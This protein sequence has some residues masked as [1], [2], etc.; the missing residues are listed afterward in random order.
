MK[1]KLKACKECGKMFTPRCGTQV[2]CS[3]P[4][5][6]YCETCGKSIEY[7]C[8]PKE[9]PRYCSTT[10]RTEGVKKH[11]LE[12]YG[13]EN[14][15]QLDTVRDRISKAK[16]G[17]VLPKSRQVNY[18]QC[19]Y[20]G[21]MFVSNGTQVYCEG[22]HHAICK[23]CGKEFEVNPRQPSSTCSRKCSAQLRK[24]TL[25]KNKHTCEIC[26]KIFYSSSNTAKYCEGPHYRS[27]PICGKLIEFHSLRDPIT[28]CSSTCA[29]KLR[30]KTCFDTFGT[31]VASQC[32]DV[33]HKLSQASIAAEE[34][35]IQTCL[36]RYGVPYACQDRNIRDK[37]R[38]TVSSASCQDRITKTCLSRYGVRHSSQNPDTQRKN[39]L[40]RSQIV[41]C[42][43]TSVDSSYEKIFYDFLVRNDIEFMYQ[44]RSI[45][46]EYNGKTHKTFIDFDV[47]G[48]LFECKG[49]HLLSGCFDHQGVP[50]AAKIDVYKK[51]HVILLTDDYAVNMFGKPNSS[52][53]N[54]LKYSDKCPYPLIGVDISLFTDTPEFPYRKDR[55]KCF[56]DVSVDGKK[57]SHEA[58]YDEVIR[59][60]MILNRIQYS[61]GFIDNKQILTALNVTRIC[62]QPSWFSKRRAKDLIMKYC[63]SNTIVDSFAGW[64]ARC[65]AT[66]ELHRI[67]VGIDL[68]KD[69]VEWHHEN[70]RNNISL[71]NALDFIYTKTCSVF[72]CPPY[73]DPKTGKCFEDYNFEGFDDSC[74]Q[75]SQCDWLKVVMKNVP[76][77][78]E[79]V[80]VCK[81]VDEGFEK[82][83]VDIIHNKSHFGDNREYI[84]CVPGICSSNGTISN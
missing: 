29:T 21:K 61:G 34:A 3:G 66:N 49:S 20:C 35:K 47:N 64:G 70:G 32:E 60:N 68:N 39:A 10:C 14:V 71:G 76:N 16:H 7:T 22:P 41:A 23:V 48:M 46:Y 44:C 62:K 82:Y 33:R 83:I 69:L 12:K 13:V 2:Y 54:G 31:R 78:N 4:H 42:D 30:E 19:K 5:I 45:E 11:N 73:S 40:A 1:F 74:K 81:I 52:V 55:P 79:Y 26:G 8:S 57:S 77:A 72:I 38:Q 6:T 25:A 15:S 27:C 9:K 24:I 36:E 28:T 51:H 43:G 59:W 67:Y 56:Y 63:T 37:I 53:S 50:I 17:I 80:M 75:L 58:F 65:Q 84:L 18:K